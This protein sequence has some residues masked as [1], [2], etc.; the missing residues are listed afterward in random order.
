[1]ILFSCEKQVYVSQLYVS[2]NFKY[3]FEG[4]PFTGIA[5]DTF[6]AIPEIFISGDIRFKNGLK[7]GYN[8]WYY[9]NGNKY[10]SCTYVNGKRNGTELHFNADG[11]LSSKRHLLN[12]VEDGIQYTYY[13]NGQIRT[14]E[15]FYKG[16]QKG[17]RLA[18]YENGQLSNKQNY[19]D[20]MLLGG[21]VIEYFQN[22]NLKLKYFV[23]AYSNPTKWNPIHGWF[24]EY[25]EN[26][27]LKNKAYFKNGNQDGVDLTYDS[28]GILICK[29]IFKDDKEI[30]CWGDC[31]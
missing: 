26:G 10:Q 17:L 21:E 23:K 27:I 29:C 22:G 20:L 12:G 30:S 16:H 13:N 24:Y 28:T 15:T 14:L 31:E 5:K 7:D 3:Y 8:V 11:S 6:T 4:N 19:V 9:E 25:Y 2:E 18:Y 1:L